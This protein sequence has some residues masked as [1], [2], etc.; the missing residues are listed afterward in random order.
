MKTISLNCR[1]LGNPETVLELH[2]LVKHEVPQIVFLM[3]TRLPIRKLEFIR[4][5]LG[6]KGYFGVDRERFGGG[7]AL[8]WDDSVDIQIQSYSKHHIDCW[9][10]NH[11]GESCRF[12]GFYGDPDTAC[13][14]HSW[15]LLRRLKGMSN[16]MWLVMGDFNE[17]TSSDEKQGKLFRCPSQ[18]AAFREVLNDCS[19]TDL[20]FHGYEFTWTNNRNQ[21][22]CVD[23]RLD[24][25]VAT[26]QW[27]DLFPG[28]TIQHFVF[29]F[30]DHLGLLLNTDTVA[31]GGHQRKKRRFH[32]EHAWLREDGCEEVI[33]QAWEVQH[34]GTHMF[35][36]VQKIKQCRMALL[37]WSKSQARR[38]PKLIAEKQA[39]LKEI[40][41]TAGNHVNKQEGR[42]LRRDLRCLLAKEEIYWRQ[43][44]RVAWLREGDR[45]TNY[46]HACANQRKKSNTIVGIR[47][48]NNIWYNDDV[49]I[50]RV[51]DN[52]FHGIYTSSNP[53]AIDTVTQE[54][55]HVVSP[56]MNEDLMMP[57]TREEVRCAL[58][59][60][61]PSKAP[62]PDGMTA[63]F[64]QKFWHIVGMDVTDSILDFLNN[65]HMLKSLNYTH[66][67]LIPK[68]KSPELMT[69][70]RP[71]S[72]CNVLYK[73]I[74]KVLVNRMKTVLPFVV[75]D[76]QSAF[77]PGRMISDNIM[78]AFEILHHLKNKRVGKV[79][80]M[81]VKL[82]MSKAYDRVEWDY[83]KKMM[84]KLGFTARWVALIMECVTSVSYSILVNGEP[85]GYVKPSR[86]L[87]QGDPLSP[88]LFLICAEGLTALLRKAERESVMQGISICRGGPQVSHLF[89][90][91]D[92]LIFCRATNTECQALQDI[93]TLY[94]SAS[95]QKI[96]T[97]KTALFF[98]Q[99]ASPIVKA[100]ILNFFGTSPTT[101]FEK[102]LGLPPVIGRSKKQAFFE[103]KDR[104][105][106]RLQGWKEKNL[107][108][109]GKAVLIKV[110]IQAIPTYAMS[111]F[112]FPAGLCEEISSMAT[113]FWWGQKETGRKIHWL[114]KKKL[115]QA[116][117]EGGLG[118]RDLQY[119]NQALLARQGWRLLKNPQ[120][121]VFRF[122]KAKY[123]PH[124]SFMEAKIRGNASYLWR[125][126]CESKHVL[127]AGMR[128][129]VGSGE[130]IR[131]WKDR[132]IPSSSTYKIMSPIRHL[133]ENASVDSLINFHSMSWNVPLLQE[134]F[135]P[136]DVEL[137]TQ[138]PLS[139]RR[140]RDTLIWSGTKKGIFTV[141]SAYYMLLHQSSAGEAGSSSS[142]EL[143]M[144]WKNLWSTQVAPKVKLFAW[145]ACRNI[146]PTKTKLFE[147][148]LTA[149]SSCSW[150]MEE[151]ET[152]DHVLWSCEFAQKVWKASS[153]KLP[154]IY[155]TNLSFVDL[156]ACLFKDLQFPLVEICITTAWS[157]WKARN[158]MIWEDKVSNAADVALRAAENAMNFLEAGNVEALAPHAREVMDQQRWVPP[159]RGDFKLNIA[160]QW[161]G[162]QRRAGMGILIRNHEGKV[163]AAMQST[164]DIVGEIDQVHAKLMLQAMKFARDIGLMRVNMEG[165]WRGLF[166]LLK[167][168]GPCLMSHGVLVDDICCLTKDFQF[169]SFNCIHANC[170]RAAQAL[171]TEAL[172]SLS[173]QVWLE[174]CPA[175][176]LPIVHF[177][178]Q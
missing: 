78:I 95:G 4:V 96:N 71:I 136:R 10:D 118:F 169:I 164:I 149:T 20:G 142:R 1:G 83:L 2:N 44:S 105:W 165:C 109:A 43:R 24:R 36:L 98:S 6:M 62:G 124:T 155:A 162:T 135:L 47:D 31:H 25:G 166:T 63:L 28:A 88:Y 113:R 67:A 46:F 115:C 146:V 57:F 18:M 158:E 51:V 56:G 19:L 138:I 92:S 11:T 171:A 54:V 119:F 123:F 145:R 129:R 14:H 134:V 97:A 94:E 161:Q 111:C 21:G 125:S 172:S 114:S 176:I 22:E 69:Q 133:D 55:E 152:I 76:S 23:E 9:V 75:S 50:E 110:V 64:F 104:I 174:D 49:G 32:F 127:E 42:D 112:K 173:E 177:E 141:K 82:D 143:S 147:K 160:C 107:S 122:L 99:N 66:I 68:V 7:L 157:L 53:T 40:Y 163:M 84:L 167:A 170:N 79:P 86:G 65:G 140:P 12:T 108:Q 81:A 58:F 116:K 117:Q 175:V 131:I 41:G 103:I 13:R 87:R 168:G 3:E 39:R 37:S 91:D 93:L 178:F 26:T 156:L 30:S 16:R 144:F 121:L 150:C 33:A 130:S 48:S 8:L 89:F 45:N 29:A 151:A 90:A 17:I 100:S 128:W 73:I 132:W 59:Q 85:K 148:G 72:L 34:V 61:S 102:Y 74:S 137:I 15:E 106:R 153:V 27:M 101:Q 38:L 5:K 80:Q 154:P 77:V 126:I 139:V 120:S 60:M 159:N 52:Y 35:R 70:F